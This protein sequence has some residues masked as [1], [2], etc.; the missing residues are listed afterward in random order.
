MKEDHSHN[1]ADVLLDQ[2][3]KSFTAEPAED[4]LY[5]VTTLLNRV[6]DEG[7]DP[8]GDVAPP[9]APGCSGIMGSSCRWSF[10]PQSTKTPSQYVRYMHSIYQATFGEHLIGPHGRSPAH[11]EFSLSHRMP[12]LADFSVPVVVP[13]SPRCRVLEEE[14]C[15]GGG[16]HDVYQYYCSTNG[17]DE[18][19]P[20]HSFLELSGKAVCP[21][22]DADSETIEAHKAA[23]LAVKRDCFNTI[24]EQMVLR[25]VL[26]RHMH[27]RDCHHC[28]SAVAGPSQ[29]HHRVGP[30][31]P[32]TTLCMRDRTAKSF[33]VSTSTGLVTAYDTAPTYSKPQANGGDSMGTSDGG[34]SGQT[35]SGAAVSD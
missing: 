14:D 32:S 18:F 3:S 20:V 23:V 26:S 15:A 11:R 2:V 7:L 29:V 21:P 28:C 17:L 24:S 6:F 35:L 31:K 16:L 13:V 34:Q 30:P 19:E 22:H 4:L 8:R 9:V 5:L 10:D 1:D 25:T 33:T 12:F 27:A